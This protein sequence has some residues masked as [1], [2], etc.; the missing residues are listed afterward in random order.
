MIYMYVYTTY[1]YF[2][3]TLCIYVYAYSDTGVLTKGKRSQAP[4]PYSKPAG[5]RALA[6]PCPE[7]G[8]TQPLLDEG[9]LSHSLPLL[10]THTHTHTHAHTYALAHKTVYPAGPHLHFVFLELFVKAWKQLD[11]KT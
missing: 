6:S 2:I 9:E 4:P 11:G 3:R 7:Y 5:G 8:V 10:H 1:I